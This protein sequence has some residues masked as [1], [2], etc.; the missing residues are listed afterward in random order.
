M[1][2]I[3]FVNIAK[4]FKR[5]S[6]LGIIST[7]T[8]FG[9]IYVYRMMMLNLASSDNLNVW[10]LKN[11]FAISILFLVFV[12]ATSLSLSWY[13]FIFSNKVM[14]F[15]STISFNIYIWH[16]FLCTSFKKNRIP[17]YEGDQ[18][19]NEIGDKVWMWKL[20]LLSFAASFAMAI[21]TTYLIEKPAAKLLRKNK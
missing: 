15:L 6:Y 5:D 3:I 14:R 13:R 11:R 17:Y 19:P 16:Q 10:Q 12:I 2:A 20:F 9:C 7:I 18:Y 21:A 8:S 4:R 1:G